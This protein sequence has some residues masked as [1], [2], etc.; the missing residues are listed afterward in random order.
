MLQMHALLTYKYARTQ[1]QPPP[2][3]ATTANLG[4]GQLSH[5]FLPVMVQE[6]FRNDSAILGFV[7]PRR[8]L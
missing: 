8:T 5:E 4:V 3:S 1:A 2:K 6:W 7:T